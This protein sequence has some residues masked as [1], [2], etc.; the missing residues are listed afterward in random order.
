MTCVDPVC[1]HRYVTMG[2]GAPPAP[3]AQGMTAWLWETATSGDQATWERL[4][5]NHDATA[6]AGRQPAA[7]ADSSLAFV[8]ATPDA[9]AWAIS[10]ANFSTD[11]LA[12]YLW[13]K[14]TGV[15]GNQTLYS[16]HIG[17]GGAS[18]RS[19]EIKMATT[20][21]RVDVYSSVGNGRRHTFNS[22]FAAGVPR[23]IGFEFNKDG[24]GDGR[25]VATRDAV[26]L[27]PTS[28]VDLGT[29]GAPSILVNVIGNAILGNFNNSASASDAFGGQLGRSLVARSGSKMTGVT[30]TGVLTQ[31]ARNALF[32]FAPLV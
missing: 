31:T 16:V 28:V 3:L 1:R 30:T 13:V 27:T 20:A 9:M 10:G 15:T 11:Y 7:G 24:S 14:P 21:L 4:L 18:A 5:G 32:A 25:V 17:T 8:A 29:G 26:V 12:I 23:L 22:M 19:F 2:S 6:T